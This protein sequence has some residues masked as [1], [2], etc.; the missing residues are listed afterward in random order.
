[1]GCGHDSFGA[2]GMSMTEQDLRRAM[3]RVFKTMDISAID[4]NGS[5]YEVGLDS[6]DHATLLLAVQ[7]EFGVTIPDED[8]DKCHSITA[9]VDYVNAYSEM[10]ATTPSD[11]R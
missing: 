6:L 8:V 2:T 3:R 10:L 11:V 5:L 9:I 7:E 4:A 1:V